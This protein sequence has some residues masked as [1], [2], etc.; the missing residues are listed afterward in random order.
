[1][2]IAGSAK[3][4]ADSDLLRASHE[5]VKGVVE[6]LIARGAGLVLGIGDEPT[7]DDGIPLTFDWSAIEVVGPAPDPAPGWRRHGTKRV[8]V[9]ASQRGLEK[10]PSGR[11]DLWS[12]CTGRS[13]FELEIIPPGWRMGGVIR[14]KQVAL[15]DVLIALAG[16]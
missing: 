6:Q 4:N 15:G 5:Y 2:H 16:C 3:R 12:A 14:S 9:V 1:M 10:I 7:N 11:T 13:D 8:R